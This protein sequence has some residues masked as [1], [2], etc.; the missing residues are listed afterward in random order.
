MEWQVNLVKAVCQCSSRFVSGT[1]VRVPECV[2]ALLRQNR[3][4]SRVSFACNFSTHVNDTHLFVALNDDRIEETVS[5]KMSQD[6]LR[7]V[8]ITTFP[9]HM[10]LITTPLRVST[11][12]MHG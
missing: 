2:H 11:N 7:Q 10:K 6:F 3:H 9:A 5:F 12:V 4:C 1:I 8:I